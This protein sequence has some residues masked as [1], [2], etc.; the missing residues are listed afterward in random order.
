MARTIFGGISAGLKSAQE[1]NRNKRKSTMDELI[2]RASLAESGYDVQEKPGM[3]GFGGQTTI[4]RTPGYVGMKELQRR[5]LEN[6]LDPNYE[7]NQAATKEKALIKARL[8]AGGKGGFG[9]SAPNSSGNEQFI[10]GPDGKWRNNPL[11]PKPM[12]PLQEAKLEQLKQEEQEAA[13]LA[14]TQKGQVRDASVDALSDIAVAKKGKRFFGPLGEFSSKAVPSSLFGEYGERAEWESNI[15]KIL[16][17]KTLNILTDLK[18][19]SK[20][21]ATGL[22]AVNEREFA[23]LQQAATELRRNYSP[24]K[25]ERVLNDMERFHIK[26]LSAQ[27]EEVEVISPDG[28]Q[29]TIP[30]SQLEEALRERYSVR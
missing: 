29:G 26:V 24:E 23:T 16:A 1:N 22:G 20:T 15:D 6:K 25:A 13:R 7:A 19:Q 9:G 28:Q 12:N 27:N 17:Q 5:E 11:I 2:Q 4:S 18:K 30:A 14:E 21:G 3:F 8:E 10:M